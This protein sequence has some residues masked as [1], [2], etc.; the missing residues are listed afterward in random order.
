MADYLC[1]LSTQL[2]FNTVNIPDML[3]LVLPSFDVSSFDFPGLPSLSS[4]YVNGFKFNIK[5]RL[6]D[7]K[8][9]FPGSL[10][11]I[12]NIL[13]VDDLYFIRICRKPTSEEHR[14]CPGHHPDRQYRL[15][16]CAVDKNGI[17]ILI[18]WPIFG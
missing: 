17:E 9:S 16:N 7:I 6:I 1:F 14:R 11:I 12:P 18:K 15:D 13:T 10:S 8:V 5:L 4:I 2:P 3:N